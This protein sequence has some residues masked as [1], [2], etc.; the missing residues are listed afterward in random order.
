MGKKSVA[1]VAAVFMVLVAWAGPRSRQ[2]IRMAAIRTLTHTVMND[3]EDF[4]IRLFKTLDGLEIMGHD[5]AFVVMATDDAFPDV[6]GY[7]M[8][9]FE[10][11]IDNPHFNWWLRVTEKMVTD[12]SA[13]SQ[14]IIA[15]DFERYADHVDPL[16]STMWG[17]GFPYNMYCPKECPTGCVTTAATQVMKY[18]E[19]PVKGQG[20]VFTYVPFGDFDG[21]RYEVDLGEEYQYDKMKD[22]YSEHL[23]Q[24]NGSEVAALMYH[25]GL[26]VKSMYEFGGTGSYNETLCHG[27]RSNMGYPY[28]VTLDRDR[29]TQEEWMD[30]IFSSLNAG[31]PIIYGGSDETYTGH[32]F[33]LDGY[34]SSGKVHVNWG[35]NGDANG[36]FDLTPLVVYHYYDFSYYQDMVVRCSTDWLTADTITVN[37]EEPGTLGNLLADNLNIVCLKVCGAINGTDL[38]TLRSM[39]GCDVDGHSTHGQLSMLDLSEVAIVAGGEPYLKEEGKELTTRDGEMPY[40]AFW[41]CSM[42]IDVILP[43]GLRSYGGAVFA[44]CNNLDRVVLH[45]GLDSDFIVEEGFVL[46][47]DRQQLIEC[48]PDGTSATQYVIPE[49]VRE[50]CAYAFSGRFLYERLIIPEGVECIGPFAFNRCFNLVRTYVFSNEPPIIAPTAIDD[51]DISIRRLYVPKGSLF[52]YR[53][54]DGWEK[55]KLCTREFDKTD[56][57]DIPAWMP[58]APS[59]IYD[60]NGRLVREGTDC[61]QISPGIYIVNG[62]KVV[63]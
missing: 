58:K 42:L 31:K 38:K 12:M 56:I 59:A 11:A 3:S 44:A 32:E 47:A 35:W 43:E 24:D 45:P 57:S 33:V 41:N 9:S 20:T 1:L 4:S 46:S 26:S 8:T 50:V 17:Q 18:N 62:K 37:V 60:L 6:L 40:K 14:R 55:Y 54:A 30:M 22:F 19:W 39:A 34:D 29:F 53:T 16:I 23:S 7:S 52:R 15:P 63:R 2:E 10:K 36:F 61:R 13:S 21:L 28:A 27:L 51:L 25:V 48:L 5:S 49:G